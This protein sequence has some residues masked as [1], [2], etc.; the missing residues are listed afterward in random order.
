[1]NTAELK[2]AIWKPGRALIYKQRDP[3]KIR[4]LVGVAVSKLIS[5]LKISW[6]DKAKLWVYGF[7]CSRLIMD[8]ESFILINE[9][10]SS[11]WGSGSFLVRE[12]GI[13]KKVLQAP[14][15]FFDEKTGDLALLMFLARKSFKAVFFN[16]V[17][18]YTH[19]D[20]TV[21][22][23]ENSG[24]NQ[25]D[26]CHWPDHPIAVVTR[27]GFETLGISVFQIHG[28]E[29]KQGYPDVIL[30]SGSETQ[31]AQT[32]GVKASI[33][34]FL[35]DYDVKMFPVDVDFLGGTQNVQGKDARTLGGHFTHME[36]ADSLREDLQTSSELRVDLACALS[37][38]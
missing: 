14:H 24:L 12:A 33:K 34:A 10:S 18:R 9:K 1:M 20:G 21:L 28:F 27:H 2:T 29:K 3:E 31:N 8:G 37:T 4:S 32:V 11:H 15:S 6:L 26:A 25:A 5:N 22:K 7:E 23:L 35:P 13:S 30:S 38:P 19:E 17:H 36:L 16:T